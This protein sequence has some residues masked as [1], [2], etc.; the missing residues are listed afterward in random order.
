MLGRLTIEHGSHWADGIFGAVH[1][2]VGH[3]FFSLLGHVLTQDGH[4]SEF[5]GLGNEGMTIGLRTLHGHKQMAGLYL[6]TVYVDTRDFHVHAT[7]HG[8]GLD[9]LQ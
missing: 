4:G 5:Q 1:L 2:H 9:V 7:F 3:A 6:P 8:S